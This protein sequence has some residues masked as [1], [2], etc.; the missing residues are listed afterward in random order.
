MS[1]HTSNFRLATH[2]A[3]QGVWPA[4]IQARDGN[5]HLDLVYP[6]RPK[7]ELLDEFLGGKSEVNS[8]LDAYHTIRIQVQQARDLG[9]DEVKFRPPGAK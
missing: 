9:V 3:V 1:W 5:R 6:E 7:Q 4:S 8:I 2:L